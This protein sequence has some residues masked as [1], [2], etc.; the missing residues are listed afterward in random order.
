[1]REQKNTGQ[2][3]LVF[4]HILRSHS[5]PRSREAFNLIN[6]FLKNAHFRKRFTLHAFEVSQYLTQKYIIKPN[7]LGGV[8]ANLD[9]N[10]FVETLA[11]YK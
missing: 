3:K 4:S 11:S 10:L 6:N 1:M 9:L 7:L 8:N 5:C 2:R